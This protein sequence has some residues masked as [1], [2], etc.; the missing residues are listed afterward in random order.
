MRTLT[1]KPIFSNLREASGELNSLHEHLQYLAFGKVPDGWDDHYKEYFMRQ[2]QKH[3]LR[4]GGLHVSLAHAY[5]HL[6]WAWNVRRTPEERVWHFSDEN[7]RRWDRFPTTKDFAD[8]W[9]PKAEIKNFDGE[10]RH[11]KAFNVTTVRVGVQLANRKLQILCYLVAKE[12]GDTSRWSVRPE[13]LDE[14][15]GS[16][17]LTESEFAR[18]MHRIYAEMNSAWNSRNDKTFVI[19]RQAVL[20]RRCFSPFFIVDC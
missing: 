1:W 8:L 10:I 12:V 15:V 4:E 18:M 16:Q 9:L 7:A 5:H 20:R 19:Q 2:E 11:R 17:P 14:R 13:G 6:N 3:P